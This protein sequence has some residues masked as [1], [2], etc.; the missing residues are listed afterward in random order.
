MAKM[1]YCNMSSFRDIWP[2]L[3]EYQSFTEFVEGLCFSTIQMQ[4]KQNLKVQS[5][6]SDEFVSINS[7]VT[8]Y[9]DEHFFNNY[10]GEKDN[11]E[12]N[13][14]QMFNSFPIK[15]QAFEIGWIIRTKDGYKFL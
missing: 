5:S 2:D 15:M 14:N 13:K 8:M 10:I 7:T 4:N 6:W 12:K 11:N 9:V 3:V 1:D